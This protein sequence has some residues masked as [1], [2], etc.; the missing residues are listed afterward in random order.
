MISPIYLSKKPPSLLSVHLSCCGA[1]LH[2]PNLETLKLILELTEYRSI[3][4]VNRGTQL[5]ILPKEICGWPIS[6]IISLLQMVSSGPRRSVWVTG[7]DVVR[8]EEILQLWT[9]IMSHAVESTN[10]HRLRLV[11][12]GT[13]FHLGASQG[14]R[15][16]SIILSVIF[17]CSDTLKPCRNGFDPMRSLLDGLLNKMN[18]Q[19]LRI[20]ELFLSSPLST[21]LWVRFFHR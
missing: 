5:A 14:A 3:P 17:H 4:S 12:R 6:C 19:N 7:I 10:I 1:L 13:K 8:V 20:L 15:N 16:N 21:R 11:F 2:M 9:C 18:L